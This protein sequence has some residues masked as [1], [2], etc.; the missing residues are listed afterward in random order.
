AS[1]THLQLETT[2]GTP[3]PARAQ[4]LAEL[5]GQTNNL[6]LVFLNGCATK[7]QVV[8]L[9]REGV[10]AVIATSVP[11]EDEMATRFAMRFYKNMARQDT[12]DEAFENAC[13]E[14]KTYEGGS[15]REIKKYFYRR[16]NLEKEIETEKEIPWGLYCNEDH[17]EVLDWKL[18]TSIPHLVKVKPEGNLG[19]SHLEANNV[20]I[21][22]LFE[23]VAKHNI[24]AGDLLAAYRRTNRMEIGEVM[25][26]IIESFP[27]PV[28][29]KLRL[30]FKSN[31]INLD[32]LK[33]LVATYDAVIQLLCFT[34]L[35]QLWDE[36]REN[37]GIFI[38]D[39]SLNH[40]D[41]FFARDSENYGSFKYGTLLRTI[42]RIF[43]ANDIQYFIEG[44]KNIGEPFLKRDEFFDAHQI[45]EEIKQEIIQEATQDAT[46]DRTGDTAEPANIQHGNIE[47]SCTTAGTQLA[48]ILK[49]LLL[50]FDYKFTSVKNIEVKKSRHE[51]PQYSHETVILS[52]E[53][54]KRRRRDLTH[55]SF[56]DNNSVVLLENI[57][58]VKK[59]L[60]LSPFIIDKN[61]LGTNSGNLSRIFLYDYQQE[62]KYGYKSIDNSHEIL[63]VSA[64]NYPEIKKQLDEFKENVL[65]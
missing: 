6:K 42:T 2:E 24:Q 17:K 21:E 61:A 4:G 59:Y 62:G 35:S 36:K 45:M 3:Q 53:Q 37:P 8:G 20:L 54:K 5:M 43:K 64:N 22:T 58:N 56:T 38:D 49:K 14:A 9:L 28:G 40:L 46:G 31:T 34:M 10:N 52:G 11:I 12:I 44:L 33:L 26:A 51:V 13:S 60:C 29:E 23:E 48:I 16:V 30:L 50:L 57:G 18:P 19:L 55:I 27:T 1:G 41:R 32:R 39:D 25:D 65:T 7:K 15:K 63:E 47:E